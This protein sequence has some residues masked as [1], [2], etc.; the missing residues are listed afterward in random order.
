MCQFGISAT[1]DKLHGPQN[2]YKKSGN[3]ISDVKFVEL[4]AKLM[5]ALKALQ[6]TKELSYAFIGYLIAEVLM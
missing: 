5:N 4:F 6:Q 3:G 1:N 2:V